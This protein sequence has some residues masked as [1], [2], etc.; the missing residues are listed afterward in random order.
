MQGREFQFS[1][2][3]YLRN[4][5]Y[6]AQIKE[7]ENMLKHILRVGLEKLKLPKMAS[8]ISCWFFSPRISPQSIIK[9]VLGL[10]TL[11][12]ESPRRCF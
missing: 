4:K 6:L 9:Q 8:N 7:L 11:N 2:V 1:V 5:A 12:P 3:V 10:W